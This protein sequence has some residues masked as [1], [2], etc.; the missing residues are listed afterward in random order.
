MKNIVLHFEW[1]H[2]IKFLSSDLSIGVK[3]YVDYSKNFRFIQII[4]IRIPEPP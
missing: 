3:H 1:G 2:L 4:H